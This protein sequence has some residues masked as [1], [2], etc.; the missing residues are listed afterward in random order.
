MS[1]RPFLLGMMN[2]Q[3]ANYVV[4][5]VLSIAETPQRDAC[6]RLLLPHLHILRGSKYGQRVASMCEKFL[7]LAAHKFVQFGTTF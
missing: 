1:R 7:R 3:Y 5:N 2:N 6:I 4:Q